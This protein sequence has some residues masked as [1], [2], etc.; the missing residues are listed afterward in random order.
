MTRNEIL[1]KFHRRCDVTRKAMEDGLLDQEQLIE[2]CDGY[3]EECE[4]E[5]AQVVVD[6]A[7]RKRLHKKVKLAHEKEIDKFL[8]ELLQDP[9]EAEATTK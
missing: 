8:A 6:E 7:A 5:L 2:M 1:E 4:A 3:R 9:S